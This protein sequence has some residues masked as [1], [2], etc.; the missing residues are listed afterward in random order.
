MDRYAEELHRPHEELAGVLERIRVR[1]LQEAEKQV[2]SDDIFLCTVRV[3]CESF[4]YL[5][6]DCG[7]LV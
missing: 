3:F 1:K 7:S 2:V 6:V 4:I 5:I